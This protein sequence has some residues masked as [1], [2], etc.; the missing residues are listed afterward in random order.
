MSY[1]AIVENVLD[2]TGVVDGYLYWDP[3]P[4]RSL[5][6]RIIDYVYICMLTLDS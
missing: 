3:Y 4:S 2:E 1:L 6:S 5:V